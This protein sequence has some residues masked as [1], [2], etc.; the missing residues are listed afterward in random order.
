MMKMTPVF[1]TK[2]TIY[3]NTNIYSYQEVYF[4]GCEE[5]IGDTENSAKMDLILALPSGKEAEGQELC[6]LCAKSVGDEE[7]AKGE[8]VET[9]H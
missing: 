1:I 5:Q 7:A 4:Q 9:K 3:I 2:T 8:L 6:Q